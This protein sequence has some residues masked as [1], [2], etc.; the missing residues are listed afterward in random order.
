MENR[1][2][3][4]HYILPI[5]IFTMQTVISLLFTPNK[6]IFFIMAILLFLLIGVSIFF[7]EI[8]I[9]E[10]IPKNIVKK[11]AKNLLSEKSNNFKLINYNTVLEIEKES[12]EMWIY[13]YDLAW[14]SK[15]N[16]LTDVVYNNLKRGK[17]YIYIVPDTE[18]VR[19]RVKA[20]LERYGEISNKDA[21]IEFLF[22]K[23]SNKLVQFGFTIYNPIYHKKRKSK[24]IVVFF[25]HYKLTDETKDTD[26][27]YILKGKETFELQEGFWHYKEKINSDNIENKISTED[28]AS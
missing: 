13:A 27:F 12:E 23:D 4:L 22:R 2:I 19:D 1:K 26:K 24:P 9:N 15:D 6:I 8:Y 20:L 3:V 25:P 21:S 14:E 7:A 17:K 18:N 11:K 10:I 28:N 16:E 5:L